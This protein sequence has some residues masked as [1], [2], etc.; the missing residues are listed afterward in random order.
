MSPPHALVIPIRIEINL[1]FQLQNSQ[2]IAASDK[3]GKGR[4][5]GLTPRLE[6]T[7]LYRLINQLIVE[8]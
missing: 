3:F 7:Q 1:S 4:I 2:P 8:F 6:V 5:N